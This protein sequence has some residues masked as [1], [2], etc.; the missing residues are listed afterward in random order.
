[1][2]LH[3]F[4][5]SMQRVL[6]CQA[7]SFPSFV[8]LVRRCDGGEVAGSFNPIPHM[9]HSPLCVPK[10]YQSYNI[11]IYI[12][13]V[14]YIYIYIYVYILYIYI[15]AH[16]S[17]TSTMVFGCV[18][19]RGPKRAFLS[20]MTFATRILGVTLELPGFSNQNALWKSLNRLMPCIQVATTFKMQNPFVVISTSAWFQVLCFIITRCY[21]IVIP[22]PIQSSGVICFQKLKLESM[23]LRICIQKKT[24]KS[25]LF[26]VVEIHVWPKSQKNQDLTRA[27]RFDDACHKNAS[28]HFSVNLQSF[29]I[30]MVDQYLSGNIDIPSG[31]DWHSHGK[32]ILF[33]R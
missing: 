3:K 17:P 16:S 26:V 5:I 15:Y 22:I 14:I 18:L 24:P 2:S 12:Y 21:M 30:G 27:G 6:P 29:D 20:R 28:A 11:S 31:Y 4:S 33:N 7:C 23:N 1:M 19:W 9:K 13:I 8:D 32:S 25:C 10:M